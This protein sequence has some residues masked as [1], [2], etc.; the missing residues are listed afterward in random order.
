MQVAETALA[1]AMGALL[2]VRLVLS[3]TGVLPGFL[4]SPLDVAIYTL[5]S[6]LCVLM[7]VDQTKRGQPKR[8]MA[9]FVGAA[10]WLVFAALI[11]R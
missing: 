7:G 4:N 9:C 2:T 3:L 5:F 10:A 11:L 8:A 6:A 1:A